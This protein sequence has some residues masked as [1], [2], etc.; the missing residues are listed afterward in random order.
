MG[1]EMKYNLLLLI[2]VCCSA[3]A[4]E[5]LI[6]YHNTFDVTVKNLSKTNINSTQTNVGFLGSQF[7][8]WD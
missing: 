1:K 8:P 6:L 4:Q 5:D 2:I 7:P 3:Y